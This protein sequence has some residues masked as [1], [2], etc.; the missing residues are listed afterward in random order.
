L[1]SLDPVAG[2]LLLRILQ[3]DAAGTDFS[4]EKIF[5]LIF[6]PGVYR[7]L[8]GLGP[9]VFNGIAP[10]SSKAMKWSTSQGQGAWSGD[11]L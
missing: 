9:E 2:D 4:M 10:P 5:E 11:M 6:L 8:E 7:S 1:V 3:R